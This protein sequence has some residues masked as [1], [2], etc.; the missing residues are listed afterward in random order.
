MYH[1]MVQ[2]NEEMDPRWDDVIRFLPGQSRLNR[3]STSL[4]SRAVTIYDDDESAPLLRGAIRP[5][6]RQ[7]LA[8][9]AVPLKYYPF[10]DESSGHSFINTLVG[11]ISA[12]I[13]VRTAAGVTATGTNATTPSLPPSDLESGNTDPTDG[14]LNFWVF[15]WFYYGVYNAIGLLLITKIFNIYS[16][17]WWPKALGGLLSS[18]LFW[19]TTQCMGVAIYYIPGVELERYQLTWV[20]LTF[21]TMLIPLFVAFLV[22]RSENRNVY[23]HS[24]TEFQKTFLAASSLRSR[25]PA[26]Y[27]RFLWFCVA[28]A[29]VLSTIVLGENYAE[30]FTREFNHTRPDDPD[31]PDDP[32][33]KWR[34]IVQSLVYVYSWVATIYIMDSIVDYIVDTRVRCYPLSSVFKLYFFM[35]YFIFYRN[36]FVSLRSWTYFFWIQLASSIWVCVFHPIC[37]TH[38]VYRLLVYL[39][40][41]TRTYDEYKRQVGRGLF[42]RNLAENAT[43]LGF[44]CWVYVLRNGPNARVYPQFQFRN[45]DDG[46]SGTIRSY[47]KTIYASLVIWGSELVSNF[48]NR[49]ICKRFLGHHVTR[50]ALRDLKDYPELIVAFV[51]VMVHVMQ[52]MLL[53]LLKLE[54]K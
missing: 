33:K 36:L 53:A 50:E 27:I 1:S 40:G 35:V 12:A 38:T 47:E 19:L 31:G 42:L 20:F 9:C 54:F 24:L 37:M 22:I 41:V 3:S 18:I 11:T 44:L 23:R 2:G 8:W 34:E 15:L 6:R 29:L 46:A 25:I 16:L 21:C 26:S 10:D 5:T 48:I 45:E 7:V 17:N 32:H 52:D 28:L 14:Q 30:L 49:S 43:M 39:F 13:A 4:A 51:L